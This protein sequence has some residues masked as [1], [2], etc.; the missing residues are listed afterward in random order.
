MYT[1]E[2]LAEATEVAH[3]LGVTLPQLQKS[4]Q[5]FSEIIDLSQGSVNGLSQTDIVCIVYKSDLPGKLKLWTAHKLGCL[6]GVIESN[7]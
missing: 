5:L 3:S 7:R 2:N 1:N 4:D 6:L